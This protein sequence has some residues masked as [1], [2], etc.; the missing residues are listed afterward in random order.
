MY[1]TEKNFEDILNNQDL[2]ALL[3]ANNYTPV[4]ENG[5]FY[6]K[7]KY[8]KERVTI[9]VND[10][11]LIVRGK[12]IAFGLT[13]N[14]DKPVI[15]HLL[16][17]DVQKE[18]YNFLMIK[19]HKSINIKL[20]DYECNIHH[21]NIK[22]DSITVTKMYPNRGNIYPTDIFSYHKQKGIIT[23]DG[24]DFSKEFSILESTF[25]TITGYL[26]EHFPIVN[27]TINKAYELKYQPKVY[28]IK[29]KSPNN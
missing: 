20:T 19:H 4:F 13:Y 11:Q 27:E 15:D 5:C 3:K 8:D 21:Y 2:N 7:N 6:I 9:K 10:N 18:R 12:T 28:T 16:I 29:R 14:D 25:P 26:N 1:I 22:E 17:G 24:K 23:T